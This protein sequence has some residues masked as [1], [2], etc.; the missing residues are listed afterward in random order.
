MKK[1]H[2]L[3]ISHFHKIWKSKLFLVMRAVLFFITLS[4][5][6]TFAVDSYSQSTRLSLNFESEKILKILEK[7]ED[8]SEFYFMFDATVVDVHQK[9]SINCTDR[10]ITE[11]LDNIFVNSNI[12]Y[13]ID[14]RQI[15]L[16]N[17]NVNKSVQQQKSVTGKVTSTEG[18]PIPGATVF[19]KGTTQGTISDTDGNYTLKNVSES[20]TVIFSFV[21]MKSQEVVVG[22]QSVINVVLEEESIGLDEVVAIGYGFVKKS[23]LTGSLASVSSEDFED[24]N[25][26]R[27]DQALQGRAAGVQV[28]QAVGA[29]GGE[30]RVRIR[31]A[32]SALG[33]NEPLYVIDGFVGADFNMI[34][35]NDIKSME[36]LKDAASTAIYG[37]RGSNGVIIITTKGGK[38]GTIDVQYRGQFSVSNVIGTMDVLSAADFASVVNAKN[39]AFGNGAAFTQ[40]QISAFKTNGGVDWQDEILRTALSNEQQLGISGGTDKT[41][42]HVSANYLDQ[43]GVLENTDYKRYSLRSNMT[44]QFND[45]LSFRINILGSNMTNMNTQIRSG[46][47]NPFVQALAW[48]P[49]TPAYDQNGNFTINDPIG[50]LK[51]NPLAMIYDQENKTERTFANAVGG[52]NYKIVKGLALDIQYGV[53]FLT[54]QTKTFSGNYV[55]NFNPSAG[56]STIQQVTLQST[57]SL[58][59]NT[60]LNDIHNISAVAVFE[61]Q[62]FK[63]NYSNATSAGLKFPDLKYD[64]LGQAESY[65]LGSSFSKW[66]LMSFLGRINY[67]L[68]DRYLLSVSVRRDGSSKFY[69]DN[70][71]STFPAMA[72]GWNLAHEDFIKE[73]NVFSKLKVRASWGWTGS[74]AIQPY[75]TQSTYDT[76][77]LYAFN[78][79]ALTTG[80]QLGNPGNQELKWET[81]E[82]KDLGLEFGFFKGRLTGEIDYFEK[83][84]TDLLLNRPL[85][86]YAGGGVYASNVG[87]IEN[88]GWE[89]SLSGIV[90]DAKDLKWKTDFN[91]SKVDNK[92]ISL[93]GISDRI[94]TGSNV[95]G[96]ATQSEFVYQPGASLGSYWGIKYLG[97]WKP[98]QEA[99]AAKFGNVPGDARY[100]DLNGDFT[101]GNEDYQIIGS[102]IPKTS[103]GWNNTVTYKSL[104]LNVFFQGMFGVDKLNYTRGASLMADRD[105]RQATLSEILD[106]YIPG[107]NETSDLPAFS[108]TNRTLT[109]STMFMENGDYI[110]LKNLSLSYNLPTNLLPNIG[111]VK[112]SLNATNLLTITKYK[113]IDP[114]ASSVGSG[115]DLNQSVDYGAYPASRT[116]TLGV[117]ITF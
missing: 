53:D 6:T 45:K 109:Q 23:D 59:Y 29:P 54:S 103:A 86:N 95:S 115:S 106:R 82:Q 71:F 19:V 93:G 94:F 100:E 20:S 81:T 47:G 107:V 69:G 44:T 67:S 37:S 48:A 62:E 102:G 38:I 55:S 30:V 83:N 34:N 28:S 77:T 63:G 5:T 70:Q 43:Q 78:N 16:S 56:I 89:V 68:K 9:S 101:I 114:E 72:V 24:Q 10:S 33:S 76:G 26:T 85:P 57:N 112:V 27:V 46:A 3:L 7:I 79:A 40:E 74:Q 52:F 21:G 35:P 12:S 84:T 41:T 97:T 105:A 31:G 104:T 73:L 58:S 4:V 60:V 75:A 108:K 39:E 90:I 111:G 66:T 113:G 50:S 80:I 51:T 87:E 14:D 42:Y 91:I 117:N 99:E 11:I 92:V 18:D 61:T 2:Y 15:A 49:T 32:N 65:T 116:Y 8:E 13:K 88:K 110:R 64:N 36:V 96:I 98:D 1:N 25:V 17:T 22:S